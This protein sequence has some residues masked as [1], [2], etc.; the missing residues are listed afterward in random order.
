MLGETVNQGTRVGIYLAPDSVS[1]ATIELDGDKN[2][3]LKSYDYIVEEEE[4]E[5]LKFLDLYVKE[6][7]LKKRDCIVALDESNYRLIQM[8]TPA[9]EKKEMK[10]ALKWNLQDQIDFS[11]ENA[12]IEIFNLPE[13]D[14]SVDKVYVVVTE[15]R[16]I[17]HVCEFIDKSGLKLQV[18]D[19]PQLALV[20]MLE[21]KEN[22]LALLTMKHNFSS[23]NLYEDS[24]LLLSRKVNLGL[25]HINDMLRAEKS[26]SEIIEMIYDPIMLELQRSLDFYEATYHADRISKIVVAPG[27]N[28]LMDFCHYAEKNSDVP[29][30]LIDLNNIFTDP[31]QLDY[32]NESR[33][34]LAIAAALR[35]LNISN[36]TIY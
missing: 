24:T 30:E 32:E 6:H 13:K 2:Y 14:F 4:E 1:V 23:I 8:Q 9:V 11:V 5:R 36:E 34:F 29:I 7:G 12:V 22:N 18:I 21:K 17:E 27:C 19:I 15:D 3:I 16:V 31:V 20:N 26:N 28:I 33:C 25:A 35:D 10:S